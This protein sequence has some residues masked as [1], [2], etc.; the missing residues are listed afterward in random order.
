MVEISMEKYRHFTPIH[1]RFGDIDMLQHVN[2]TKYLSYTEE[3]RIR[4]SYDV[5]GW[6]GNW[7]KLNMI[8]A[9]AVVNFQK[10]LYLND[11][12]GVLTRCSR[13]GKKSFDFEYLFVKQKSDHLQEVVATAMTVLV[14]YDYENQCPIP[15]PSH[16]RERIIAFEKE[17]KI[18]E[19]N[20]KDG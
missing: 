6:D 3:A 14:A 13:I 15:L 7:Q 16:L 1:I 2:N 4:Y 17:V 8:L 20:K 9:K 12:V 5:L 19:D 11:K 18:E 10:P